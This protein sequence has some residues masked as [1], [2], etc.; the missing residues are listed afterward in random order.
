MSRAKPALDKQ[1]LQGF[2]R[3]NRFIAFCKFALD[4]KWRVIAKKEKGTK[5]SVYPLNSS[6]IKNKKYVPIKNNHLNRQ[7]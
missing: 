7:A 5:I 2:R 1:D 6:E 4:G 3:Y